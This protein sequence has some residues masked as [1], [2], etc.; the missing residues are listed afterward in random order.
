MVDAMVAEKGLGCCCAS[1]AP[2]A[3]AEIGSCRGAAAVATVFP[4]TARDAKVW[5]KECTLG[6]TAKT[7]RWCKI[8]IS[9][10]SGTTRR[11]STELQAQPKRPRFTRNNEPT[12]TYFQSPPFPRERDAAHVDKIPHPVRSCKSHT[13]ALH[14]A[15]VVPV[16]CSAP[17][18]GVSTWT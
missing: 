8:K 17:V 16:L 5:N 11:E 10:W 15:L 4:I 9:E 18:P 1:P 6:K 14:P 7:Q 13:C 12:V 2:V 3:V